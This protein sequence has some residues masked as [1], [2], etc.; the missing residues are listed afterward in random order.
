M[1]AIIAGGAVLSYH[2][3][4]ALIS[5][6]YSVSVINPN[7]NDCSW[8]AERLKGVVVHGDASDPAIL[9]DAEATGADLL[10]ALTASDADNLV[11]CQLAQRRFGIARVIALAND[12]ANAALFPRLGIRDV[13]SL[14]HSI[15]LMVERQVGFDEVLSQLPL[16]GGQIVATEVRLAASS[17]CVGLPV[18]ELNLPAQSLIGSVVRGNAA[19]IPR[20]SLRFEAGDRVLLLAAPDDLGPALRALTGETP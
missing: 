3:G 19:I 16:A 11:T 8:L 4:R 2:L 18:Q 10:L 9:D 20:G 17:P 13:V 5:K 15:S 14:T 7:E 6:G 12:P 1:R